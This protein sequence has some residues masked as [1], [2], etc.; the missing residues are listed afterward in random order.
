[1]NRKTIRALVI[2]YLFASVVPAAPAADSLPRV[3]EED[4]GLK[5]VQFNVGQ[6]DAALLLTPNGDAALVD[7]GE[8]SKHGSDIADYLCNES[9]NGVSP[10]ETVRF[11]FSSHYDADHIGGAPGLNGKI[12]VL[13][14][15]DQGPSKK[16]NAGSSSTVYGRYVRYIGDPDGD[17]QKD[18]NEPDFV[19]YKTYPGISLRMGEGDA[20]QLLV[21][22]VNG[23]TFGRDHDLPL[24]PS[25]KKI[26]ENPGSLALSVR[27]K[28]FEYLT[29]GDAFSDCW[30][31]EPD[32]EGALIDAEAIPD[33]PDID[34]LKVSHHG[35]D[36]SSGERFIC[37]LKP[38]LAVIP[39]DYTGDHLPKKTSLKVLETN[40]ALTLVTG[41][42]TDDKGNY[43]DAEHCYDDDYTPNQEKV[44][45]KQGTVTILVSQDGQRIRIVR[46]GNEQ[47]VPVGD[48][49]NRIALDVELPD[50]VEQNQPGSVVVVPVG[51]Q[52][53]TL[54]LLR[55]DERLLRLR[56]IPTGRFQGLVKSHAPAVQILLNNVAHPI[57]H[58]V[59]QPHAEMLS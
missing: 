42:A 24:D 56:E 23:N 29:C 36:T 50:Q 12:K 9:R 19:R 17:G 3:T 10:I 48:H 54:A 7:T 45:D 37:A 58:V 41:K 14:A 55:T 8:F 18:D 22:S 33:G 6:A 28:D 47:S 2:A 44:L 11:L 31:D 4:W 53:E 34:V 38:E 30:K 15:Y 27:L 13:A 43:H 1:M 25:Q 20:V 5:I 40:G 46:P 39:S 49:G 59:N 52:V 51:R 32:S 26:N 57:A 16:R 35:S 21:I